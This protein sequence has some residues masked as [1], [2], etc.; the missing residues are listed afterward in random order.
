MRR[1]DSGDLAV[2][3]TLAVILLSGTPMVVLA[4]AHPSLAQS[5]RPPYTRTE[6]PECTMRSVDR[7]DCLITIETIVGT[8]PIPRAA[9]TR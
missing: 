5:E 1:I 9:S 8:R 7:V 3:F 6:K 4:Q 2:F